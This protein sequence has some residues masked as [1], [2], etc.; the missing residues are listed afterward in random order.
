MILSLIDDKK[1]KKKKKKKNYLSFINVKSLPENLDGKKP[2]EFLFPGTVW[3]GLFNLCTGQ[4]RFSAVAGLKSRLG[5]FVVNL[6]VGVGQ[7]F[8]VL[9][10]LV[11]WGWSIWW[12]VTL[13]RLASK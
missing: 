11:G 7:L 6:V 3:S 4:P 13:V 5:A 2:I 8:T 12:G 10:C 9:F 1:R